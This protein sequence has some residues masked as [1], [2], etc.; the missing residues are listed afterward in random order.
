M[1]H[2]K[3]LHSLGPLAHKAGVALGRARQALDNVG[4]AAAGGRRVGGLRRVR[5]QGMVCMRVRQ[6]CQQPGPPHQGPTQPASA[7]SASRRVRAH[8]SLEARVSWDSSCRTLTAR[9]AVLSGTANQGAYLAAGT[10]RRYLRAIIGGQRV[11]GVDSGA[12]VWLGWRWSARG[13]GA[14]SVHQAAAQQAQRDPW[15]ASAATA[16]A[17]AAAA[18][19]SV[20][21][22]T[23]PRR[24][25]W[26]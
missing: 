19:R 14:Q 10:D 4:E 21:Q 18:P 26:R 16:A 7:P 2:Y 11:W 1:R 20:E 6:G 23:R 5:G 15:Q 24:C 22:R 13:G 25:G 9:R 12:G 8:L 17:P 3:A